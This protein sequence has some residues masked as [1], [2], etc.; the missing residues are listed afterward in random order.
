MKGGSDVQIDFVSIGSPGCSQQ[1]RTE[2]SEKAPTTKPQGAV[3]VVGL[4]AAL[5]AIFGLVVGL[6]MPLRPDEALGFVVV[7][8]IG[9]AA[10]GVILSAVG[11]LSYWM[12]SNKDDER[13]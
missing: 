7:L 8:T 4:F 12:D 5:R 6:V 1:R 9:G 13:E 11:A 2:T 10:I 3:K